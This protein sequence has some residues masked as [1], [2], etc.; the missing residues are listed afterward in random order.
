MLRHRVL[1][2]TSLSLVLVALLV[3]PARDR[4]LHQG[5]VLTVAAVQVHLAKDPRA[6][7]NRTLLLR[8]VAATADCVNQLA[9]AGIVCAPPQAV[10]R[11]ASSSAA[12]ARL[13]LAVASPDRLLTIVR[14]VPLLGSMAP[15]PQVVHW[16]VVAT[17]RVQLQPVP[18]GSC[19]GTTCYEALVLDVAP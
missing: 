9:R 16:E 2:I 17:Y 8:G 11:D 6:W 4:P 15:A 18:A 7:T 12:G 3:V 14:R 5:P 1:L 10:L 19:G 13:P